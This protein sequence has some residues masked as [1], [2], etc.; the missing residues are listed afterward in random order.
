TARIYDNSAM[1]SVAAP[2]AQAASRIEAEG[3]S[4]TERKA[5]RAENSQTVN[6]QGSWLSSPSSSGSR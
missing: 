4:N 5:Y 1:R 6:Q 3:I 2:A